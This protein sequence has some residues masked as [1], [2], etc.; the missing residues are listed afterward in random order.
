MTTEGELPRLF[1]APAARATTGHR[2]AMQYYPGH[3]RSLLTRSLTPLT[4]LGP[5]E[6]P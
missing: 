5:S 2:H 3:A 1:R 4:P 6:T